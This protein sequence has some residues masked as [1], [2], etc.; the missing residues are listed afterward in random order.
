MVKSLSPSKLTSHTEKAI[1]TRYVSGFTAR[2]AASLPARSAMLPAI[3]D[4]CALVT[5]GSRATE[6]YSTD[7]HNMNHSDR[8]SVFAYLSLSGHQAC[9][10]PPTDTMPEP[11]T[12]VFSHAAVSHVA[13]VQCSV[14]LRSAV[15]FVKVAC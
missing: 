4:C 5:G 11:G 7:G 15:F 13:I 10:P 12:G 9:G 2:S 1:A 3:D 6:R 14:Q 8:L